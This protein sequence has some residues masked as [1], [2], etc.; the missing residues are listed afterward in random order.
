V[1]SNA[2]PGVERIEL[3]MASRYVSA[4][5]EGSFPDVGGDSLEA[6]RIAA[7]IQES[8][9]SI[10][11]ADVSETSTIAGLARRLARAPSGPTHGRRADRRS[12]PRRP[13]AER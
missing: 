3:N 13:T 12:P 2:K 9:A 7:R 10:T 8:S 11:L 6:A 4:C 5:D 1:A